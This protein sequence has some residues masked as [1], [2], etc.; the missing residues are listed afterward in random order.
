VPDNDTANGNVPI[1]GTWTFTHPVDLENRTLIE[2]CLR[3]QGT[4]WFLQPFPIWTVFII[5]PLFSFLSSLQNLQPLRS[6]QLPIMVFISC[7]AYTAN[8]VA[9]HYIFNRSDVVSAIGAFTVGVMGN[10]YSRRMGGTAFTSMVTGVLFLVPVCIRLPPFKL[11]SSR[12]PLVRSLRSRWHH[13]TRQWHR[14]WWSHDRC[15]HW[16]HCWVVYEPG[17][18]VHVRFQEKRGGFLL[19]VFTSSLRLR[20]LTF[21]TTRHHPFV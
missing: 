11:S 15:H 20:Y 8:R 2:G 3:P 16:Y 5:V 7:A 19:L 12:S 6:K 4:R 14:H 18:C 1:V 17:S 21:L 13:S 10:I 9:N